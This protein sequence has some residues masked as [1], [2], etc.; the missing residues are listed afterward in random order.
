[1]VPADLSSFKTSTKSAPAAG[2]SASAGPGC[3]AVSLFPEMQPCL[4]SRLH[5]NQHVCTNSVMTST[6][7]LHGRRGVARLPAGWPAGTACDRTLSP[8]NASSGG[9]Q[10][11]PQTRGN[12]SSSSMQSS[13]E[14]L[15]A[16]TEP[17]SRWVGDTPAD[18]LSAVG[19]SQ[20]PCQLVHKLGSDRM[21]SYV[22]RACA[23]LG[24]HGHSSWSLNLMCCLLLQS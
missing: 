16:L 19:M 3:A 7:T 1:M 12:R 8:V 22:I 2:R 9:Q 17:L 10:Q 23:R 11:S 4:A 13:T 15:V 14:Q 18:S 24:T 6:V 5:L 20:C 21:T